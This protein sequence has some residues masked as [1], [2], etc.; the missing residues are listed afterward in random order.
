LLLDQQIERVADRE[1]LGPARPRRQHD[2]I[3]PQAFS[4]LVAGEIVPQRRHLRT[5]RADIAGERMD[6]RVLV[7]DQQDLAA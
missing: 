3:R 2:E 6:K 5:G 7:I 1:I 4:Q